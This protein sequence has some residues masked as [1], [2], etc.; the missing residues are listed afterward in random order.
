MDRIDGSIRIENIFDVILLIHAITIALIYEFV[1]LKKSLYYP[2][3]VYTIA[4]I[5]I[6]ID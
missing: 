4:Y 3:M 5:Y 6:F 2:I 1:N